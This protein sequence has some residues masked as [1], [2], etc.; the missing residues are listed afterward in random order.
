MKRVSVSACRAAMLFV[1]AIPAAAVF[2]LA[3]LFG[4][5]A[6]LGLAGV[7]KAEDTNKTPGSWH[8]TAF[9]RGSMGIRVIDYWAR[10]DDMVARTVING[11]PIT[12]IVYGGRYIVFDGLDSVGL[13]VGRSKISMKDDRERDRP[14]GFELEDLKSEGGEKIDDVSIGSMQGEIWQVRDARGRRKLWVSK[15][16]PEVPLRVETFDRASGETIDLDYQN[17]VF[18]IVLPDRFFVP[19]SGVKLTRIEYDAYLGQS[20]K[21]HMVPVPILYPDLLHGVR[22]D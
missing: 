19:P 6:I 1:L 21:S 16:V 3:V 2:R 18:D 14:F 9:V 7:A 22:P 10:G 8:A 17:W 11:R 20:G 15:G 13:D 12:T 4:L 5:A